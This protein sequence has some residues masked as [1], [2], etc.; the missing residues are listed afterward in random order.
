MTTVAVILSF[1]ILIERFS[2]ARGLFAP[3][4]DL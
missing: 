2:P 1:G 4:H 3:W